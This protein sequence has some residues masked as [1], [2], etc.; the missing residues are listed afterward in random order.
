MYSF[1]TVDKFPITLPI[2]GK[3]I[4]HTDDHLPTNDC[5]LKRIKK[6]GGFCV[7]QQ[8][9][10]A[11]DKMSGNSKISRALGDRKRSSCS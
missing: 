4:F 10:R 2:L 3:C 6:M 11:N 1:V 9:Y 8:V 7:S 5:E